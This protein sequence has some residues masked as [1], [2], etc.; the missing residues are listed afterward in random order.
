VDDEGEVDDEVQNLIH[1]KMNNNQL[2][3]LKLMLQL[4]Q[5]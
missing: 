1:Q 5:M 2:N 3:L 4:E